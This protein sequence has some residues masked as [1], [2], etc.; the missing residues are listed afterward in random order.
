MVNNE[1]MQD[2]MKNN[3]D[4]T[5]PCNGKNYN[6]EKLYILL[7]EA[8]IREKDSIN[9]CWTINSSNILHSF[10]LCFYPKN[11]NLIERLCNFHSKII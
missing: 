1:M 11:A 6:K 3:E 4:A 9:R 7:N 8:Y 5:E 2:S 10:I